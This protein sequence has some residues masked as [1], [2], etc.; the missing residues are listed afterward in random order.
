MFTCVGSSLYF[1]DNFGVS[2]GGSQ[3]SPELFEP[4]WTSQK[5]PELRTFPDVPRRL[6]WKFSDN[7]FKSFFK[8][9]PRSFPDFPT[10]SSLDFPDSSPDLP[11]GQPLCLGSLTPSGESQTVPPTSPRQ[12]LSHLLSCSIWTRLWTKTISITNF[13]GVHQIRPPN[14]TPRAS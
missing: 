9:F 13:W 2:L 3:T 11:R 14:R 10:S 7:I 5:F 4:P 8:R 1:G 6:P 12:F